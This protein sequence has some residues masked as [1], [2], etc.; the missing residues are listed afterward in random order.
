[1]RRRLVTVPD[2][3]QAALAWLGAV[4]AGDDS[5]LAGRVETHY[6]SADVRLL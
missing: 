4:D 5:W 6:L 1:V 3:Y 2:R